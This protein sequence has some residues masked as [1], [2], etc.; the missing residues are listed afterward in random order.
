M[1]ALSLQLSS[2]GRG[3]DPLRGALSG[4]VG[5]LEVDGVAWI[6]KIQGDIFFSLHSRKCD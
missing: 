5:L 6:V 3:R 2:R 1:V 4:V